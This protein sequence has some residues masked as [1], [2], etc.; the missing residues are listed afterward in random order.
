MDIKPNIEALLVEEFD[1]FNFLKKKAPKTNLAPDSE[2]K[3]SLTAQQ[4][5]QIE[6]K[7]N[8]LLQQLEKT[9][10][11]LM[12]ASSCEQIGLLYHQIILIWLLSI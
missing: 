12:L 2:V 3:S 11:L 7:I 10:D 9:E 8:Q 5:E 4:M 6:Q 1:M